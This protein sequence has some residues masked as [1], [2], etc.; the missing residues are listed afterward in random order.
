[1]KIDVFSRFYDIFEKKKMFLLLHKFKRNNFFKKWSIRNNFNILK[2]NTM[3]Y[4]DV[5]NMMILFSGWLYDI[6][7]FSRYMVFIKLYN[8]II[9]FF[10]FYDYYRYIMNFKDFFFQL[11]YENIEYSLIYL[12]IYIKKIKKKENFNYINMKHK[13]NNNFIYRK[14]ML[15]A[16]LENNYYNDLFDNLK[17]FA[18]G[19]YSIKLSKWILRYFYD[20]SEL[21]MFYSESLRNNYIN[22]N[23]LFV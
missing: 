1:L 13:I 16:W 4:L 8:K 15:Y 2:F 6:L 5:N 9:Q 19:N 7:F 11:V 17:F 3:F 18:K 23:R 10:N 20:K 22:K 14:Y 21:Y 12:L